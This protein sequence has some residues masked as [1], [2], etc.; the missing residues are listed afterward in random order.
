MNPFDIYM[1]TFRWRG[2]DDVRPW[3][4][5]RKTVAGW[6]CFAISRRDYDGAPF[7]LPR[8]D[9]AFPATGL[10]ATSY[11]Y[12]A[13]SYHEVPAAAFGK[14]LGRLEGDLLDQFRKSAG[15]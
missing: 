11:V 3:L 1:A 8:G 14:R 7:E 2:C 9:P 5:V 10:P 6:L 4:L 13:E 12:D 15:V